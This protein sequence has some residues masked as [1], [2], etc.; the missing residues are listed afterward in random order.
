MRLGL[1][2]TFWAVRLMARC[3]L[4]NY[5]PRRGGCPHPPAERSSANGA[6]TH[7]SSRSSQIG[8]LAHWRATLARPDEGVRAYVIPWSNASGP[9]SHLLGGAADGALQTGKLLPT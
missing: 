7:G 4:A 1:P 6:R 5:C 2:H 9:S 8:Q 3:R